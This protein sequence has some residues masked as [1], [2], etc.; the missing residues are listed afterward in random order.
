M[1][2]FFKV[3]VVVVCLTGLV[4]LALTFF[5]RYYLTDARIKSL[6]IPPAEQA[7]G[8]KVQI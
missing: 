1:K 7:L 8:R 3:G 4:L 2:N 6:I 5:V